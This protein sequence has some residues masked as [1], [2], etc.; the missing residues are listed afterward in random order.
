VCIFN[1]VKFCCITYTTFRYL[2]HRD[3]PLSVLGDAL[4]SFLQEPDTTT[5]NVG[6]LSQDMI[7]QHPKLWKEPQ[8]KIWEIRPSRWFLAASWKR[9]TFCFV[10]WV[11]IRLPCSTS[12][13]FQVFRLNNRCCRRVSKRRPVLQDI[14]WERTLHEVYSQYRLWSRQL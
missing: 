11:F 8:P 1:F 12:D 9:W 6:I 10:L 5:R 4:C 3:P 13:E 7:R 2:S 14:H